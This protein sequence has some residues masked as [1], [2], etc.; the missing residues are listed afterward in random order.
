MKRAYLRVLCVIVAL[1]LALSACGGSTSNTSTDASTSTATE[2][3]T[4]TKTDA[5]ADTKT[6]TTA[7]STDGGVQLSAPGVLPIVP[8]VG[9]VTLKFMVTQHPAIIDWNTNAFILWMQEQTNVKLEFDEIP[10]EGRQEKVNLVLASG[11]YPDVF[12]GLSFS[13]AQ[14]Q[15]Y[16]V[17][18]NMLLP[19]GDLIDEN[20]VEINKI[21]DNFPGSRNIITQ[22]DGNIYSMPQVNECYHCTISRKMWINQDWLDALGLSTPKTTDEFY[23]VLKAFKEKDPNGNGKADEIPLAGAHADGWWDNYD[24]FLMNAFC[25]YTYNVADTQ[26]SSFGFQLDDNDNVT[27]CFYNVE[28]MKA[29]FKYLAKLYSEGLYYEGSFSNTSQQLTQL[30]ESPEGSIVGAVGGGYGGMFSQLG[31][32]RYAQYRG[33]SPLKGPSGWQGI[34]H[35]PYGSVWASNMVLS[36]TCSNPAAAVKW[37]DY[38]Y[39]YDATQR[40]YLGVE[41]EGWRKAEDGEVGINGKPALYTQLVPWQERD[42]Q[43][44]HICQQCIDYRP[45]DYRLGMTYDPNTDMYSADGLE[46]LLQVVSEDYMQYAKTQY[47]MPPIK[48]TKDQNDA[49]MVIKTELS[50]TLKE[51]VTGFMNGTMDVDSQYDSFV[52]LIK[53]QGMDTLIQNYQDG[54]KAQYKK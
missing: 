42:P 15:Q 22:L 2:T 46:K 7:A 20:C 14:I 17:A 39:S 28:P 50:N 21:W 43:N 13:E 11:N 52:E 40:S 33:L 37:G 6:D 35:E 44:E 49:M 30:V 4:E 34:V 1:V 12:F 27:T 31:G 47:T 53:S 23:E 38:M 5:T 45:I 25:Y 51:Y 3:K 48:F 29:G 24:A 8:N 16:G 26:A 10:L 32:E 54:Y 36:K 41:G 19:L 18:E 9:D